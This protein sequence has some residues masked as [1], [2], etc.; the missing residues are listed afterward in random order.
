MKEACRQ[1]KIVSQAMIIASPTIGA[2]QWSTMTKSRLYDASFT[3]RFRRASEEEKTNLTY[4]QLIWKYVFCNPA[5][6]LVA[7][8]NV[9]LY[10]IRKSSSCNKRKTCK[11]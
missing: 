7:S 3:H 8:V 11:S 10:F 4:W 6:L 1:A 2:S 5:L 9:A